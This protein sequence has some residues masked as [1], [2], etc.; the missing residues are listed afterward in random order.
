MTKFTV[1]RSPVVLLA[2]LL[3]IS[4]STSARAAPT[5]ELLTATARTDLINVNGQTTFSQTMEVGTD[6]ADPTAVL[7]GSDLTRARITY[8]NGRLLFT[9]EVSNAGPLGGTPEGL[10]YGW[11]FKVTNGTSES[12]FFLQA[13]RTQTLATDSSGSLNPTFRL[14]TSSLA[15]GPWGFIRKVPGTISAGIVQ[16]ELTPQEVNAAPGAAISVYMGSPGTLPLPSQP[17]GIAVRHV[18]Y[19]NPFGDPS[20]LTNT[21]VAIDSIDTTKSV[22]V[23]GPTVDIGIGRAELPDDAVELTHRAV[24]S[25]DGSFSGTLPLPAAGSYKVVARACTDLDCVFRSTPI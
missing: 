18:V 13:M 21:F 2:I 23:T 25:S 6:A 1:P 24:V 7:P 19:P 22:T 4:L 16:W 15:G 12:L 14:F 10:V 9:L 20:P 11:N 3:V 8:E 5:I 17:G